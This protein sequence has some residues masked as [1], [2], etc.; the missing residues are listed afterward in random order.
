MR[1]N[2]H[3][4]REKASRYSGIQ[5]GD[6]LGAGVSYRADVFEYSAQ[7]EWS[8]KNKASMVPLSI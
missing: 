4:L 7:A 5:R 3:K 6:G 8:F 2:T 1:I